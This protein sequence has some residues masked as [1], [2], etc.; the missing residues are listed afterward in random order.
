MTSVAPTRS[1]AQSDLKRSPLPWVSETE[2]QRVREICREKK[3][4]RQKK[5]TV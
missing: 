4:G 1:S 5:E 3:E 2:R